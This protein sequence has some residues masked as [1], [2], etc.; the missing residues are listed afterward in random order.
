MITNFVGEFNRGTSTGGKKSF[1]KW[2]F[3]VRTF[4]KR[5]KARVT[6]CELEVGVGLL[7]LQ[8]RPLLVMTEREI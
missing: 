2:L 3:V 4:N 1:K 7:R 6:K 8:I 5:C